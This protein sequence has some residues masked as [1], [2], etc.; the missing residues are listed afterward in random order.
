[1]LS[2][3]RRPSKA[4][5]PP[6]VGALLRIPWQAVRARILAD[7]AR[8]GFSD[9]APTHLAI[10]Q[11]PPP[12]GVR[13]IDLAERAGTSKQAMNYLIA[14]LEERGYLERRTVPRRGR[15]VFLTPRCRRVV[16]TIWATMQAVEAEWAE[17]LGRKRFREFRATL[18]DLAALVTETDE[19]ARG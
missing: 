5:G 4:S 14:Q 1:M 6:F 18:V 13:P 16:E 17:A 8:A 19:R 15:L 11:Y 7:L 3:P 10:L 2:S 9:I 12:D